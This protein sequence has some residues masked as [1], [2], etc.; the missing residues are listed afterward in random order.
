MASFTSMC[1]PFFKAAK[2]EFHMSLADWLRFVRTEQGERRR[3]AAPH[4]T[5]SFVQLT[6]AR[7][8]GRVWFRNRS[9]PLWS[10]HSRI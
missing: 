7:A 2:K 1:S 6:F 5:N 10:I 9:L 8:K 4:R 3:A